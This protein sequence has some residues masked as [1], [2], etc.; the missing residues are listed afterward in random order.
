M[1]S[2]P[3]LVASKY[4]RS[5]P[6]RHQITLHFKCWLGF[7]GCD[8]G[9]FEA[10]FSEKSFEGAA[11]FVLGDAD[12]MKRPDFSTGYVPTILLVED[13]KVAQKFVGNDYSK[14]YEFLGIEKP[15]TKGGCIIA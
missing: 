2:C 12:V 6:T 14:I 11:T 9:K 3:Y 4:S 10:T 1:A 13:G 5:L 8:P 7:A 15:K